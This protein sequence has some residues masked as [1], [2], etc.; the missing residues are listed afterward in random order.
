METSS[1]YFTSPVGACGFSPEW[2][3]VWPADWEKSLQ[4][5]YSSAYS[6]ERRRWRLVWTSPN[7]RGSAG[8]TLMEHILTLERLSLD[9]ITT[10]SRWQLHNT[11]WELPRVFE[12]APEHLREG[13]KLS[14]PAEDAQSP[15]Q[16]VTLCCLG[17]CSHYP[18]SPRAFSPSPGRFSPLRRA[19]CSRHLSPD[20]SWDMWS[21]TSTA[22]STGWV[23]QQR[24]FKVTSFNLHLLNGGFECCCC[25]FILTWLH[26]LQPRS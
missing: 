5:K 2:W 14:V 16:P 26:I 1:Q 25:V 15:K 24:Q 12:M 20:T 4:I 19:I 22:G 3:R 9:M 8:G 17:H 11:V 7:P 13:D 6:K 18:S 21:Q 10:S 23:N